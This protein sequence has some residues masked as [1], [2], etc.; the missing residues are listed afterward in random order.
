MDGTA[1]SLH[2]GESPLN[3]SPLG[4]IVF[5][6]FLGPSTSNYYPLDPGARVHFWNFRDAFYVVNI[7]IFFHFY[8]CFAMVTN[9]LYYKNEK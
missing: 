5:F 6:F 8:L 2:R 3:F 1:S 7:N 9:T 4:A